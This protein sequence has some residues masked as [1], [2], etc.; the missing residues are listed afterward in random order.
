MQATQIGSAFFAKNPKFFLTRRI[1]YDRTL[2][3]SIYQDIMNLTLHITSFC[4]FLLACKLLS[5]QKQKIHQV[6][7][8][9][10][11]FRFLLR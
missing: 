1:N 6:G 3:I 8:G 2:I 4:C 7:V 11:V 5:K 9:V 10:F